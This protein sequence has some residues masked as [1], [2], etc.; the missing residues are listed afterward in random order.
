VG[1]APDQVT[2]FVAEEVEPWL[3]RWPDLVGRRGDVRV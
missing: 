1:R 3:A 2:E